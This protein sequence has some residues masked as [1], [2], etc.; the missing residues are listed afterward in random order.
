VRTTLRSALIEAGI[1]ATIKEIEG[2]FA[3]PT[4]LIGGVDVTGAASCDL[5]SCRL[6]LPT[7][8]Q[9]L[10]ALRRDEPLEGSMTGG[11][12]T[13]LDAV[14]Q[15]IATNPTFDG[16]DRDLV[17]AAYNALAD[18]Q[19]LSI[20][21]LARN[22]ERTT[23]EVQ[24][25][26]DLCE[27]RFDDEAIVGFGGLSVLPTR[28]AFDVRGRRLYTWCAWDPFFIAPILGDDA[29]VE[30]SCPVTDQP[31]GL[32]V[33]PAGPRDVTPP[34]AVLSMLVPNERCTADLVT[35]FCGNVLL[36]TTAEAGR[37]WTEQHPGT[38]VI[39]IDDAFE[40]GKMLVRQR[41]G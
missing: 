30:S 5:P 7:R 18:G 8:E 25:T 24:A 41:A 35:N 1:E 36:F 10:T 17:L 12:S 33:G 20:A 22:L 6:D 34:T 14:R 26:I 21:S 31:V 32:T 9:I 38:F 11:V 13:E 16:G 39:G 27:V 15:A 23:T 28:H 2:D 19:R 3:S 4:L 40:L 37:A 29:R